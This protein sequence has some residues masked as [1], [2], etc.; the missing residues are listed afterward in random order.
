MSQE[1]AFQASIK[2]D[3]IDIEQRYA[4]LEASWK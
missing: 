4:F 2:I 1:F 3:S